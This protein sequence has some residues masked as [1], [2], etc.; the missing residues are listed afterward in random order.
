MRL[1][2]HREM[3]REILVF[4]VPWLLELSDI[5]SCVCDLDAIGAAEDIVDHI[6]FLGIVAI[7]IIQ[8]VIGG[9]LQIPCDHAIL[10]IESPDERVIE[11]GVSLLG[12]E[13]TRCELWYSLLF[14]S[15]EQ[16]ASFSILALLEVLAAASL[17]MCTEELKL[18]GR[19]TDLYKECAFIAGAVYAFALGVFD[20]F[21]FGHG[22]FAKDEYTSRTLVADDFS[23]LKTHAV[24]VQRLQHPAQDTI[25]QTIKGL[26]KYDHIHAF[27]DKLARYQLRA[28][29]RKMVYE[30]I[31]TSGQHF[32]IVGHNADLTGGC[33]VGRA[34]AYSIDR[35]GKKEHEQTISHESIFTKNI[36]HSHITCICMIF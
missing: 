1:E 26:L 23:V 35:K 16:G 18:A 28:P 31:G 32:D 4:R 11:I 36:H 17:H 5:A 21:E 9:V 13:V 2:N 34:A 3:V 6:A 8:K 20:A 7:H 14:M 19:V 15:F 12:I 33:I 22:I 29:D 30:T 25:C 10:S 27:C 24:W